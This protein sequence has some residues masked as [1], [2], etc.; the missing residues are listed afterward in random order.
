MN[1]WCCGWL[2]IQEQLRQHNARSQPAC[3]T[4]RKDRR[5]NCYMGMSSA[6]KH[7]RR[8]TCERLH[9]R[10]H[11][12]AR[13]GTPSSA[14]SRRRRL[15]C[16]CADAGLM[17]PA[18]QRRKLYNESHGGVAGCSETAC[19]RCVTSLNNTQSMTEY[20]KTSADKSCDRIRSIHI[21]STSNGTE[22]KV[23]LDAGGLPVSSHASALACTG[24]RG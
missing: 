5:A 21:R 23:G 19:F 9:P 12:R 24:A 7:A 18:V 8:A 13:P 16:P 10:R 11:G 1:Q 14:P 22:T 6:T 20:V 17:T 2:T 4:K 15:C 3:L